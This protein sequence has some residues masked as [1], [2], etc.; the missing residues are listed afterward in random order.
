MESATLPQVPL[1]TGFLRVYRYLAAAEYGLDA[2][3]NRPQQE[4]RK[5]RMIGRFGFGFALRALRLG[6]A[7]RWRQRRRRL[8]RRAVV[9]AALRMIAFGMIA[10]FGV[11]RFAL[12]ARF[13]AAARTL[14]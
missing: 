1:L 9:I 7:D 5:V 4:R 3:A 2:G 10:A 8:R 12:A 13:A 11:P 6:T 14:P